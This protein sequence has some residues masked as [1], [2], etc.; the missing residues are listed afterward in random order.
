MLALGNEYKKR[1]GKKH[2]SI[3]KCKLP[4][5]YVPT[6]MPLGGPI[7][8]PPQAMPDEYKHKDSI[9]AYWQYYIHG[10]CH[11]AHKNE[12]R[13]LECSSSR[14]EASSCCETLHSFFHYT[15]VYISNFVG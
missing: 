2:L 6:G 9:T 8:Q 5:Q 1:Y 7:T 13:Y 12:E 4:L 11:I 3:S 14:S 15:N 10:K